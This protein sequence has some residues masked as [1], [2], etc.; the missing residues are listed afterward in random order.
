MRLTTLLLMLG[1]GDKESTDSG[2]AEA[3]TDTS[4]DTDT[5]TSP[6]TDTDTDTDA[7]PVMTGCVV[8]SDGTTAEDNVRVQMCSEETGCIPAY[9]D[10]EGCYSYDSLITAPYSFDP[11]SRFEDDGSVWSIPLD[12]ISFTA[13]VPLHL[14]ETTVIYAFTHVVALADGDA[15]VGEGLTLTIDASD[16]SESEDH[17]EVDFVAGVAVDPAK[18]GLPLTDAPGEVVAMWYLGP[19]QITVD[20]WAFAVAG[21]GLEEGD[22][23][24]AYNA[25]YAGY[26]WEH[27]GQT[28]VDASGV[29]RSDDGVGVKHLSTLILVRE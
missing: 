24:Q 13:D 1:C 10:E 22:T 23:L 14:K 7:D 15:K 2:T 27:L 19:K 5:D 20:S 9:P 16:I 17:S 11:V 12:I 25:W 29:L 8:F 26:Q 3:D 18:A 21:L 28:T 4:P 6:D